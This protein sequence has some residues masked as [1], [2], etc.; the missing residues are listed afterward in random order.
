MKKNLIAVL[1]IL[2][3]LALAGPVMAEEWGNWQDDGEDIL[4]TLTAGCPANIK[5]GLSPGV[6]LDYNSP[7]GDGANYMMATAN[8]NGTRVYGT[9]FNFDGI[10]MSDNEFDF[11][12]DDAPAASTTLGD[13]PTDIWGVMG[14]GDLPTAAGS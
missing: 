10:I 9:Q 7:A 11:T 3:S 14:G 5:L 1:A 4:A 6:H 13:W 8:Q 2:V 12:T